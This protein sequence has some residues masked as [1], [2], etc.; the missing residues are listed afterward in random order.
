MR[1]QVQRRLC[2]VP[3]QRLLLEG[4]LRHSLAD[5]WLAAAAA[6]GEQAGRSLDCIAC[7]FVPPDCPV[8][9]TGCISGR[10]CW[11][12]S[13]FASWGAERLLTVT[14]RSPCSG[15]EAPSLAEPQ[16]ADAPAPEAAGGAGSNAA[17]QDSSKRGKQSATRNGKAAG[18]EAAVAAAQRA[19]QAAEAEAA[20]QALLAEE[21]RADAAKAQQAQRKV[22]LGGGCAVVRKDSM[23]D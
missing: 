3:V 22:R 6:Q 16:P 8:H 1:R 14:L 9:H 17:A 13:C 20:M 7:H 5:R 15:I 4:L 12:R 11:H 18:A 10:L 21:E 19:Q 23:H 2:C